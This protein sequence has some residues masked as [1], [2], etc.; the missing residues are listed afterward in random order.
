[1]HQALSNAELPNNI[2]ICANINISVNID[3]C[4]VVKTF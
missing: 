1:M 4:S 2:I 3:F